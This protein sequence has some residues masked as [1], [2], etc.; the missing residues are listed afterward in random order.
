M[1]QIFNT[2]RQNGL[3]IKDPTEGIKITPHTKPD[4]AKYLTKDQA[5]KLLAACDD[6]KALAFVALCLY[7]GL[8]RE[9]ALGLQWGDIEPDSLTVN[10]AVA[11]IGNQPDPSQELKSRGR[12]FESLRARQK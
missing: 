4:K 1:Q 9:E 11:F 3:M 2:A 12:G 8:R 10:R 5:K 6:P 7:C